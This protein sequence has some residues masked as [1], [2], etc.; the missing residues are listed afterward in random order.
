MERFALAELLLSHGRLQEALG[1]YVGL[2]ENTVAEL[3]FFGP[4]LLRR[5][6][7]HEQ[8]GQAKEAMELRQQ[9]RKLWKD[10]D[11]G[12]RALVEEVK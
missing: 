1:W 12:L 9:F 10:A 8:L 2:G 4:S 3:V 6:S 11:P 7:I 5:A